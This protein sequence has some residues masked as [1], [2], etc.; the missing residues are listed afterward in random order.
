[1]S[2]HERHRSGRA[3]WL[4]A[5]VLG[6]NDALVSTASL[7]LGV[8]AADSPA[9]AVLVAG[10]AGVVAGSLSMAVGEYISV[11]AQRDTEHADIA[12]ETRELKDFPQAELAE[13]TQIYIQRGLEPDLA[14]Q[15]AQ[16]LTR[17][18]ALE[19]HMRD[20]LGLAPDAL[21]R[22][23]QAALVSGAS[24]GL[25]GLLPILAFLIAPASAKIPGIAGVSLASMTALGAF[26]G[27]LG[28]APRLRAALR[29]TLGGIAAMG[30]TAGIGHLLGVSVG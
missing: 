18:H 30:I 13:L 27:H 17:H 14:L 5:A 3:A 15:V 2:H 24:F 25:A 20:E 16:Q 9:A 21:A 10:T 6:A 19:A 11:S 7:M 12:R 29:V 28:G 8:A 26:G 23:L 4:R 22:P 1:M